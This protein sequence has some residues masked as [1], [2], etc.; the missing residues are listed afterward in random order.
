MFAVGHFAIGYLTGKAVAKKLAIPINLPLLLTASIIPDIDLLLIF[1]HHRGPTHSLITML[2][3]AAPFLYYYGRTALPYI[4]ALAS[5]SL[6]GDFIG[7]TQLFWPL[8]PEWIGALHLNTGGSI[9]VA[10]EISFFLIAL[11]IMIK[12]GDLQ[13]ITTD[14]YRPILLIPFVATL[15]PMLKLGRG[16]EY[17]LPSLLIIP[18]LFYLA[19]LAYSIIIQHPRRTQYNTSKQSE[20]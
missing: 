11:P 6:I 18:S 13:K 4:T 15:G 14:K 19:L 2:V 8:S 9:S 12:T 7:G 1:L 17:A 3:I 10:L 5:H 20:T 16:F